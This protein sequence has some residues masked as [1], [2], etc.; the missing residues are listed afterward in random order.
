MAQV[1]EDS[2]FLADIFHNDI[3]DALLLLAS[4]LI[5]SRKV[6]LKLF[7]AHIEMSEWDLFHCVLVLASLDQI[8]GSIGTLANE[9]KHLE[10]ADKLV[11]TLAGHLLEISH[12]L[13]VIL[14]L[15]QALLIC[16]LV[17]LLEQWNVGLEVLVEVADIDK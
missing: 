5:L 15:A 9:I 2:H 10:A 8:H 3:I 11:L 17:K 1:F 16:L 6:L 4:L 7:R 13:E 14:D 12:L